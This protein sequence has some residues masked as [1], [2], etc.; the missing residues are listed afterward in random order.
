MSERDPKLP[1]ACSVVRQELG[2]LLDR[3]LDPTTLHAVERHLADCAACRAELSMLRAVTRAVQALPR[4]APPEAMRY[5][6]QIDLEE[7]ATVQH[8]TVI[9]TERVVGNRIERHEVRRGTA[10]DSPAV[11]PQE[12]LP[13]RLTIREYRQEGPGGTA[14]RRFVRAE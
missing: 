7:P 12:W 4:P 2:A 6:L 14:L 5:R 3:E 13:A 11:P 8:G 10:A 9:R 1:E